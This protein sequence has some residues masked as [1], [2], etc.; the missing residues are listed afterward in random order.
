MIRTHAKR[1]HKL[2]AIWRG[3]MKVI[4]S[5]SNLVFVAEDIL[6][7]DQLVVRTQRTT[8]YPISHMGTQASN[9]LKEGAVHYDARYYLVNE[10]CKVRKRRG[11]YDVLVSCLGFEKGEDKAWESLTQEME[12]MPVIL[13][14]F[15]Y[16]S[17][18]RNM[19]KESLD[20]YFLVQI[21]NDWR[22]LKTL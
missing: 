7:H 11:K 14:D 15:L 2:Q 6:T 8:L 9:E 22:I 20:L 10:I 16:S 1:N 13:E 3:P 19:K 18:N 12:D 5:E 17:G 21:S 4:S